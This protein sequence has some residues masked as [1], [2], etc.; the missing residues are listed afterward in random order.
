MRESTEQKWKQ[1][2]AEYE[3][4]NLSAKDSATRKIYRM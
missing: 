3:Q 4:T 2:I 1:I